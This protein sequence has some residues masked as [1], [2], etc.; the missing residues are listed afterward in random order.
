MSNGDKTVLVTGATGQQ[1]GAVAQALLPGGWKVRALTR[2]PQKPAALA[3]ASQGVEMLPGDL[4]Q[5]PAEL[6]S[7]FEGVYGVFSVQN[8]WESGPAGEVQQGKNLAE[9]A[10][11]AGVQH[12]VYSSVGGAE[13]GSGLSHFESKWEIEN[14]IQALGLP[15]TVLR[16]TFF[17][18][19]FQNLLRAE[20]EALTLALALPPEKGLQMVAVEDIGALAALAFAQ[21]EKFTGQALELAG[22]ELTLPQMAGVLK[23]VLDR[24]VQFFSLPLDQLRSMNAEVANMFE[25]LGQGGYQADIPALRAIYPGLLNFE[26]WLQRTGWRPQ[27]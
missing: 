17:M 20:G 6:A 26:T 14:H 12:L 5:T 16:P 11:I 22:D 23:R 8:F 13:R 24:P 1:G 25:W 3:L 18:S 2:D 27:V 10:K 19:N 21:P 9:A 7:A 4:M 15:A